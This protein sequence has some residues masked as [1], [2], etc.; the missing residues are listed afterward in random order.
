MTVSPFMHIAL[1]VE[2]IDEARAAFERRLGVP[3]TDPFTAEV[4]DLHDSAGAR[5]TSVRVAY[6][7]L[8]SP[9]YELLEAQDTGIFS[10]EN[11]LGFHHIGMWERDCEARRGELVRSGLQVEATSYTSDGQIIVA[12]FKPSPP[13]GLRVE[14][15][16]EALRPEIEAL[17]MPNSAE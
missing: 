7:T 14:I 3:F 10:R 11:G 13:L 6:S 8:G 15:L 16:D 2:D 17:T 5:E 4:A 12:W 9:H 1:L